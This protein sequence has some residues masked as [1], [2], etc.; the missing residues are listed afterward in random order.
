MLQ[1]CCS[2]CPANTT[3]NKKQNHPGLQREPTLQ[4]TIVSVTHGLRFP[5]VRH[6]ENGEFFS[7][8]AK[9]GSVPRFSQVRLLTIC[10]CIYL[11]LCGHTREPRSGHGN[12]SSEEK[13]PR[14]APLSAGPGPA[15]AA[16]HDPVRRPSLALR[17]S[18]LRL[19]AVPAGGRRPI[20]R[21]PQEASPLRAPALREVVA[22]QRPLP[23][24]FPTQPLGAT[25][26]RPRRATPSVHREAP[27]RHA[28]R[29][30][31]S[32]ARHGLARL[33]HLRAVATLR[34]WSRRRRAA[35]PRPRSSVRYKSGAGARSAL[36]APGV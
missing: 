16:S 34:H 12:E 11:S 30:R 7:A 36:L 3:W 25:R 1:R 21:R 28:P 4:H 24:A 2:H 35:R 6:A 13:R 27:R 17:L 26:L 14:A 5:T 9:K 29:A 20:F 31:G 22:R 10:A 18:S 8:I 23:P 19:S 32:A 15:R 33:S